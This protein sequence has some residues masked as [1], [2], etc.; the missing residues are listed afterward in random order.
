MI[1]TGPSRADKLEGLEKMDRRAG[2]VL[3]VY[4]DELIKYVPLGMISGALAWRTAGQLGYTEAVHDRA[5]R[6]LHREQSR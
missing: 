2:E 4:L 6:A 5:A 1:S 3:R